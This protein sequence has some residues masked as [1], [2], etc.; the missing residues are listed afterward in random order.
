MAGDDSVALAGG[1]KGSTQHFMKVGMVARKKE[2][3]A[4]TQKTAQTKASHGG[5]DS[6]AMETASGW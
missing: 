6:G 3:S 1:L 4:E 2:G 5:P